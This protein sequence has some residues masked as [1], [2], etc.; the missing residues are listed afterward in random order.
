MDETL[1]SQYKVPEEDTL[2]DVRNVE[3]LVDAVLC[4]CIGLGSKSSIGSHFLF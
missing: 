1:T 4:R 2:T 3:R